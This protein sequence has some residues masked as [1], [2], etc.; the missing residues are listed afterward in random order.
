M[1]SGEIKVDYAAYIGLDWGSDKHSVALKVS[2]SNEIE[3]YMLKQTPEDLHAWLF[4]LRDKFGG[5]PVAVAIEQTKGAVIHALLG[6]D[7]V[8]IFRINPKSLADYRKAFSPSGAKDD[9]TDAEYLL[10]WVEIHRNRIKPWVP[11]DA[12]T[13]ALQ[14][15]V[16]FRREL[17]NQRVAFTNQLTQALKEYFPQALDWGGEVERVMICDFLSKWPTLEKIKKVRPDTIR[18][19][20]RQHG[21]RSSERIEERLKAI[22]GAKALTED[23]AVIATS[24]CMVQAIVRTLYPLIESI[25]RLDKEIGER[26]K[27][28]PDMAIFD[29]FPGAGAALAPR[30]L[31]AMGS[32]RRR[33]D[34]ADEIQK[35][36][37]IAPVTERSGK[38]EW[39]HRRFACSKFLRQT[40]H[41]FA[42][43]SI[44][45]CT[46]ARGYYDMMR[47]RGIDHHAAV[48]ALAF[49]WIRIIFRCWQHRVC[50]KEEIYIRALHKKGSPVVTFMGQVA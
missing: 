16:E 11:D 20:Y 25:T 3:R 43:Q 50:Y 9:P 10:E 4:K 22:P 35:Y 31:A 18:A 6:Y 26:F 28:H 24:V 42:G 2:G 37:G 36:S 49:K 41:E 17:V 39:V 13:R 30:L 32:D 27:G 14:K 5:R 48:R 23:P 34:S 1:D 38:H 46:W 15:L 21:C 45:F 12:Q 29:S 33:F 19:F 44:K 47:G 7:F 8:H 40:F